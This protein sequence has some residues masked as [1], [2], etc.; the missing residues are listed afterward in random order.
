MIAHQVAIGCRGC[1]QSVEQVLDAE[2]RTTSAIEGQLEKL[3]AARLRRY[4][5]H[6]RHELFSR[7]GEIS[8]LAD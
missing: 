2:H 1:R 7:L 6:A 4:P 5:I 3:T 8:S